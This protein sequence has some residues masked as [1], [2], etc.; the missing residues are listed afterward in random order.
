[1]RSLLAALLLLLLSPP[2]H[3][4]IYK[5]VD[6]KGQVHYSDRKD[7]ADKATVD[8]LKVVMPP[9]EKTLPASMPD[10]Q[11]READF[12]R[13]QNQQALRLP[14]FTGTV[15][16]S[17]SYY[18]NEPETDASRCRLARDIAG[19]AARHRNGAPTDGNDRAIANRDIQSFCH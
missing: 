17:P 13:R 6:A 8:E 16:P 10:W 5:W 7:E 12:K 2:G 15:K 19:G 18:A 11:R 1:M 3:A 14:V 9:R 4:Q